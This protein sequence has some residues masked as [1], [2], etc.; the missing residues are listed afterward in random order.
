MKAEALKVKML[1][2]SE[3][4]RVSWFVDKSRSKLFRTGGTVSGTNTSDF[5][6][7]L[8]RVGKL[9]LPNVSRTVSFVILMYAVL[10][11]VVARV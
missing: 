2:V 1:T 7:K 6:A 9:L 10:R 5:R 4:L 11:R 3:K 8:P